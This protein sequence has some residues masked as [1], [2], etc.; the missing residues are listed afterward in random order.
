MDSF[1]GTMISNFFRAYDNFD[2]VEQQK[3]LGHLLSDIIE[4]IVKLEKENERIEKK[5]A[6]HEELVRKEANSEDT[7]KQCGRLEKL[8]PLNETQV[9]MLK[10]R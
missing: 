5:L 7:S 10:K 4:L 6:K 3:C 8:E 9:K 2:D 1:E